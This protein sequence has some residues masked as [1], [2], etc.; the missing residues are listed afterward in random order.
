[1]AFIGQQRF[2]NKLWNQQDVKRFGTSLWGMTLANSNADADKGAYRPAIADSLAFIPGIVGA[3]ANKNMTTP[4]PNADNWLTKATN[5]GWQGM[6]RAQ[7]RSRHAA[8]IKAPTNPRELA[9]EILPT[10]LP[11]GSKAGLA[12]ALPGVAKAL[13]PVAKGYGAIPGI[14][15]KPA[16]L[17]AEVSMPFAQLKPAQALLAG[18]AMTTAADAIMDQRVTADG[19]RYQGML[20]EWGMIGK[21]PDSEPMD[22]EEANLSSVMQ[23]AAVNSGDTEEEAL[24][25]AM[26]QPLSEEDQLVANREDDLTRY[27]VAGGSL[28]TM[29][30][31]PFMHRYIKGAQVA[32][33]AAAINP[34]NAGKFDP[35]DIGGPNTVRSKPHGEHP[36]VPTKR[37]VEEQEAAEGTPRQFVGQQ[38]VASDRGA[39]E[40]AVTAA[41]ESTTPI[42]ATLERHFG[43]AAADEADFDLTALSRQSTQSRTHHMFTTGEMPGS[44]IK[45]ERLYPLMQNFANDLTAAE[46]QLVKDALVARSSLDDFAIDGKQTSLGKD[47][48]GKQSTPADLEA[49]V[50]YAMSNPKVATHIKKWQKI[51]QD[52]LRYNLDRGYITKAEYDNLRKLRPN[53]VPHSRNM[54]EDVPFTPKS[55]TPS[56]N[57]EGQKGAARSREEFG[58][59]SGETGVGDPIAAIISKLATSVRNAEVNDFR[60]KTLRMLESAGARSRRG[61]QG[62]LVREMHPDI[63]KMDESRD[64]EVFINGE[65][66]VF[67]VYDPALSRSLHFSPRETLAVAEQLKQLLQSTSTGKLNPLFALFKAPFFDAMAASSFRG[68]GVKI[69]ADNQALIGGYTGGLQALADELK[70][71]VAI[72]VRDHTMRGNSWMHKAFLGKG[73]LNKFADWI[74]G[75]FDDSVLAQMDKLGI[76]SKTAWGGADPTSTLHGLES[77][78]PDYM[79]ALADKQ[80]KDINHGIKA[81]TMTTMREAL[82]RSNSAWVKGKAG[83]L[84]RNYTHLMEAANNGT[85]YSMVKANLDNLKKLNKTE[86]A[87]FVADARRMSADPAR[88]G[89]NPYLNYAGSMSAWYQIGTQTLYQA[90]RRFKEDPANFLLNNGLNV[91]KII[92]MYYLAM[93]YDP[94]A[95]K[96][97]AAKTPQQRVNSVTMFGGADLPIDSFTRMQLALL[98]PMIDHMVGR[99]PETGDMDKNF[100]ESMQN[101][102]EGIDPEWTEEEVK[103]SELMLNEGMRA[104]APYSGLAPQVE[105]G[106]KG[107]SIGIA[108]TS[109]LSSMPIANLIQA[110]TGVDPQASRLLGEP[111]EPRE[112]SLSGF[113]DEARA[114]PDAMT[115]AWWGNIIRSLT[116]STGAAFSDVADAFWRSHT[117]ETGAGKE[118]TLEIVKDQ[119]TEVVQKQGGPLKGLFGNRELKRSVATANFHLLNE[120]KDGINKVSDAY[121]KQFK[122]AGMTGAGK[123]AA[124]AVNPTGAEKDLAGTEMYEIGSHTEGL[125]RELAENEGFIRRAQKEIEIIE[126]SK[127]MTQAE[128]NAQVNN[129]NK[130][131]KYQQME[132]LRKI[133]NKEQD[134]SDKLGKP[135]TYRDLDPNEYLGPYVRRQ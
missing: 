109:D 59:I 130:E 27:S 13:A 105:F 134:L 93:H 116:G 74:E 84:M 18:T 25:A 118:R 11:I 46:Q 123:Y 66:R 5:A 115:T 131:K 52:D 37:V 29:L 34:K 83:V 129:W 114:K 26:Q 4:F 82:G 72:N 100:V 48:F 90:G 68:K 76:T 104:N 88:H 85:R 21:A 108:G 126:A 120:R 32:R 60:V 28:L 110:V 97:D 70:R 24:T 103:N 122:Q 19:Q 10:F 9:A 42:T 121:T 112:Q 6:V 106:P 117:D 58:G 38:F 55:M 20:S 119:L 23:Q 41:F 43:R 127:S 44:T 63:K 2:L 49:T 113:E 67:R 35:V 36:P 31:A 14:I 132:M 79:K 30:A 94:E 53:Y 98:L 75:R 99:N 16:T 125:K 111:K 7:E 65:R 40:A 64:H 12:K 51:A 71:G 39:G 81:G 78:A 50:A 124:E 128:K 87:K 86:R 45:T 33:E 135:F 54:V 73:N 57:I 3:V 92:G 61:K 101:M 15:R 62:V 96:A 17:A 133:K 8:G 89:A 47:M 107:N 22:E 102:M 1:M 56:A 77:H 69:G 91:G 95:R 80:I